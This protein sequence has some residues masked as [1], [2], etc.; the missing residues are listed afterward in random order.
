MDIS[1][2]NISLWER[3]LEKPPA[4]EDWEPDYFDI[5]EN[6]EEKENEK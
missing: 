3:K 1:A 5:E 2:F 4:D 6:K